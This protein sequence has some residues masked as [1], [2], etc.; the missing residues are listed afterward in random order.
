MPNLAKAEFG[1]GISFP[2]SQCALPFPRDRHL[3]VT[4][5]W[6]EVSQHI[7]FLQ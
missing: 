1:L 7:V 3:G 2:E 6:Y 4:C 5:Y